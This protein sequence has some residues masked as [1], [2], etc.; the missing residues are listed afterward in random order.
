MYSF[1][2]HVCYIITILGRFTISVQWKLLMLDQN[3]RYAE[4]VCIICK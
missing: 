3:T 4:A 2:I 1:A